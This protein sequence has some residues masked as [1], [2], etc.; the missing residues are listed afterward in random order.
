MIASNLMS[1]IGSSTSIKSSPE[2][3]ARIGKNNAI[4]IVISEGNAFKVAS[5]LIIVG[6]SFLVCEIDVAS[7]YVFGKA[8][9]KSRL[10]GSSR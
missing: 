7:T 8:V 10:N 3:T 2:P 1:M 5:N 4:A 6:A 9:T